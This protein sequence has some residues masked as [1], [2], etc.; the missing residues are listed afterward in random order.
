MVL[1]KSNLPGLDQ[2]RNVPE[3]QLLLLLIV[4]DQQMLMF[5]LHVE[6]ISGLWRLLANTLFLSPI[7]ISEVFSA[8]QGW[9]S[10]QGS[11]SQSSNGRKLELWISHF[12]CCSGCMTPPSPPCIDFLFPP[13]YCTNSTSL[14]SKPHLPLS[15]CSALVF[16]SIPAHVLC[17]FSS[18]TLIETSEAPATKSDHG[19]SSS[20]LLTLAGGFQAEIFPC[21]TW[22]SSICID[23]ICS[24]PEPHS[25][26]SF[27]SL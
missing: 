18:T 6:A 27:H 4:S 11:W 20:V 23:G 16:R 3:A 1:A 24:A 21:P 2:G 8:R 10:Q 5:W 19:P 9:G 12:S 13:G 14:P 25:L 22:R 7:A 17:S 15:L 26:S